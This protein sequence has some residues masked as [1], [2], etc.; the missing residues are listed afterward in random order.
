MKRAA[1]L[2]LTAAVLLLAG[3][4]MLSPAEGPAALP[5][6][7]AEET[8]SAAPSAAPAPTPTPT[9]EPTPEPTPSVARLL[10]AGDLVMHTSLN[11]EALQEDGTY[12]YAP[13]FE[14]VQELISSADYATCCLEA[15]LT[16]DG[17]WTGYPTFH[18]PDGI[19]YSL[20]EVGFDLVNMASNHGFDAWA[21]G[22]V[23][24]LDVLDDAGLDHVG[25]YRSAEERAET[26][27]VL[28]KDINGIKIAFL[29]YTY[30]TNGFPLYDETYYLNVY[31][32]DY[33]TYCTDADWDMLSADLEAAKAMEPDKIVVT[34]HWG[35]EYLTGPTQYQKEL[36]DFLFENGADIII[37]G[38]PHVPEPMEL[39]RVTDED[40]KERTCFLVYSLGNLISGQNRAYTDLTAAVNI[41]LTKDP[42]TGETEIT[43]A[44][45]TPMIMIDLYDY[46]IA[47][48]P[49][50]C[51]LWDL[52]EAIAGY[53]AGD[54][55]GVITPGMYT[56]LLTSLDDC[57]RIFG[58]LEFPAEETAQ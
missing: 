44:E 34:M 50:R 54:D 33:L 37:G 53:E 45:Y 11:D 18:T 8:P 43:A 17:D 46:G 48:A 2:I 19:A 35:A 16:G 6:P 29:D 23:R 21:E 25:A 32:R 20:A 14:D 4:Y 31:A 5:A 27:G 7:E 38:H 55:R 56:R 39:R 51:R 42:Y 58:P 13:I 1:A 30:G 49:W 10:F 3:S 40:G 22:L 57:G 24:T 26:S 52:E 12:D 47:D 41:E 36:A 28:Q 9:P 15:A